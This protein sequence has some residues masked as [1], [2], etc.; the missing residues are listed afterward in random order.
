MHWLA[1]RSLPSGAE[2]GKTRF[3]KSRSVFSNCFLPIALRADN[4]LPLQSLPLLNPRTVAAE[5][6]LQRD[7]GI[8]RAFGWQGVISQVRNAIPSLP[9]GD[10][11]VVTRLQFHEVSASHPRVGH[12]HGS[13]FHAGLCPCV[14]PRA[15]KGRSH[16]EMPPE[17]PA[18]E[19]QVCAWRT[20]ITACRGRSGQC[21]GCT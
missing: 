15:T 13:R 9:S 6:W 10:R 4:N 21:S 20:L 7:Q 12:F 2:S 1:C 5:T 14:V 3:V 8:P 17:P 16:L 18:P 11:A 19:L